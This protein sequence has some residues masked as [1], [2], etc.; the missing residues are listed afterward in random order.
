MSLGGTCVNRLVAKPP[1]LCIVDHT[2]TYLHP[3]SDIHLTCSATNLN[4]PVDP[5]AKAEGDK[6]RLEDIPAATEAN[7]ERDPV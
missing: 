4:P 5:D 3:F 6:D 2:T 7:A 1:S